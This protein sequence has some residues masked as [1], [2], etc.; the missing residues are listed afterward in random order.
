[1]TTSAPFRSRTATA[2]VCAALA[3]AH[4]VG[5]PLSGNQNF[6]LLRAAA[7]AGWGA[8][9]TDWTARTPDPVPVFTAL[10]TPMLYAAP[11]LWLT[12]VHLALVALYGYALAR[13]VATTFDWRELTAARAAFFLVIVGVHSRALAS[14]SMRATG[15]DVRSLLIDGVAGQYVLGPVLQ[16]SMFGVF[17]LLAIACFLD[18]RPWLA[19]VST[20]AAAL[21]HTTYLI[22]AAMLTVSFV[23]VLVRRGRWRTAAGVAA[24]SLALAL[25]IVFYAV[26]TFGP[27]DAQTFARAAHIIA[28]E[29]IAIHTHVPTWFGAAAIF[30]A[31]VGAA[32]LVVVRRRPI[33]PVLWP[34]FVVAVLGAALVAAYP[35]PVIALQFPWRVSVWLMPI[36]TTLLAAAAIDRIEAGGRRALSPAAWRTTAAAVAVLIAYGVA[37][38]IRE[39]RSIGRLPNAPLRDRAARDVAAGD[40]YLIPPDME[41]FRLRTQA[42]IVVDGKTHPYN[43]AAVLE[44]KERLDRARA[45]YAETSAARCHDLDDIATSYGATRVVVPAADPIRCG[46]TARVYSDPAFA[47]Y[48][49]R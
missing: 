40:V 13:I 16:P 43:D 44:W 47:I 25:P 37:G 30:K 10:A 23:A 9:A 24:L 8:L 5:A 20:G 29:R 36:S 26:V 1:M 41:D 4:G 19:I 28:D 48:A 32:A 17:V 21:V 15:L 22:S 7:R 18:Q 39:A 46:G 27:S 3:L 12:I 38:S 14:I 45:F 35:N 34:A 31:A 42:A 2:G 6:Y 33:F 11:A 49:I